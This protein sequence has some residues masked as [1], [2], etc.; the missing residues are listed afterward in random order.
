MDNSLHELRSF[1]ESAD[2]KV[3]QLQQDLVIQFEDNTSLTLRLSLLHD[4]ENAGQRYVQF[5]MPIGVEIPDQY[6]LRAAQ[7]IAEFNNMSPLGIFSI[8]EESRP[9][10]DYH[11]QVPAHGNCHFSLL[12]AIQMSYLFAGRLL[13]FLQLQL[14]EW[15]RPSL[16]RPQV[17]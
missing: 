7:V 14:S 3:Q 16:I 2:L 6:Y 1:L 4:P 12:E 11:F 13:E 8:S 10:F 15:V 17:A 9:Y 5:L